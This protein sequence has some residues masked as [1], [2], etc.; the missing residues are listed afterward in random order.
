VFSTNGTPLEKVPQ[1]CYLGRMIAN[2]NSDWPALHKN[3]RK[4]KTKWALISRPLLNTG[5]APKF[6]GMFYKAIVQAVLLYGC[7]TWV[8]TPNI[9]RP[10]EG[11]HHRIA[12]RISHKM[13]TQVTGQWV[14]P[15]ITKAL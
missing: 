1:F 6:V 8:V 4:A 5:V 14:Y 3:L 9:L 11:L 15:P 12:R 7:E 10:M 2:N 13:P